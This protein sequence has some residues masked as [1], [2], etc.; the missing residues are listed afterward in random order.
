MLD[1]G[2]TL[3]LLDAN[4]VPPADVTSSGAPLR[5]QV[6]IDAAIVA[7]HSVCLRS[8]AVDGTVTTRRFTV[9]PT[10]AGLAGLST[11]LAEYPQ[12]QA[13]VEPTSMTWLPLAIALDRSGGRLCLLGARHAARL[14]G[15]ITGKNKSDVIDADVLARAGEVFELHPLRLPSPGQLALR[16][17]VTR[18]GAAVVDANRHLR[19]LISLARWAFPDVWNAF[20]GHCRPPRRC[21]SGGRICRR[22]PEPA[23]RR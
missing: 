13:V 18:R 3:V 22:W 6:G 14:R 4:P 21:S 9:P 10:L 23:G 15:A 7:N 16:R 19:R 11:R 17:V 8:T 20:G 2:R 5:V 12:V 1:E